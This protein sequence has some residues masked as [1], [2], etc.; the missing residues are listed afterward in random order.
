MSDHC[1]GLM[2][3]AMIGEDG[4]EIDIGFG[5]IW[6]RWQVTTGHLSSSLITP[7]RS[8]TAAMFAAKTGIR[9]AASS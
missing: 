9:Y 4:S 8:T 3:T 6:H 7:R 1:L 5:K 2:E